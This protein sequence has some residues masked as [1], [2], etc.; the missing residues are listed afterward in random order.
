MLYVLCNNNIYVYR[1]VCDSGDFSVGVIQCWRYLMNSFLA[2]FVTVILD[3]DLY[4]IGGEERLFV[5]DVIQVN[6]VMRCNV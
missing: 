3:K 1:I 6:D 4:V 5:R 2:L